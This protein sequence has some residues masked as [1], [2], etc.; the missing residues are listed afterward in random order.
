LREF[1]ESAKGADARRQTVKELAEY[2]G[3][4]LDTVPVLREFLERAQIVKSLAS[5]G[6]GAFNITNKSFRYTT[7]QA[8]KK[9]QKR[10]MLQIH[11]MVVAVRNARPTCSTAETACA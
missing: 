11:Y 2:L 5:V 6:I 3:G 10:R 9:F 7:G 1:L 4:A 8:R